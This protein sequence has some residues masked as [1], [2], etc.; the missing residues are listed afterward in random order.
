M[1]INRKY[2]MSVLK[3]A[4]QDFPL[5]QRRRITIEYVVLGG[6]NDTRSDA[7]RLARYL[8][9]LKVKVNLIPWNPFEEGD[10]KRP[11]DEDVRAFQKILVEKGLATSVR[12]SKGLDIGAACGQLDGLP[13]PELTE[14]S[15][16]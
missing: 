2:N 15:T 8:H 11:S 3:Q 10:F 4:L 12:I 9:G 16:G 1:P 6:F 13:G 14:S 7:N 5:P